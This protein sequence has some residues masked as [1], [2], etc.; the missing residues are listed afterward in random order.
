MA[1]P[2]E[3]QV[4]LVT[5]ATRGAGRGIA[6]EL[7]AAG[8]TVY[9]TGRTT[10]RQRSPLN[11]PETIE[12]TAERVTAAGGRG[13]AIQV[14]HMDISQVRDLV[15]RIE[16]EQDGQL[17]VLVNDIW[18]GQGEL[19]KN[20]HRPFWEHDLASR[21][22]IYHNAVDTH[23]ITSW[24]VAPIMVRRKTGL[25][26]GTTDGEPHWYHD[27]LFYDLSKKSVMRLAVA[28]AE[29]MSSYGI[30]GIAVSP[31]HLRSE[32]MLEDMGI[33]EETWQDWYWNN[34]VAE[35]RD[36]L[37]S[38]SPRY[39]G[40]VIAALAA[41]PEVSRWNGQTTAVRELAAHYDTMDV[42]G[43]TPGRGIYGGDYLHDNEPRREDYAPPPSHS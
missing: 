31:G 37:A 27:N 30:T 40:R 39:T 32:E 29:E 7:G 2:L 34:P 3:G 13:I 12:E 4:A 28:Y 1:K 42:N 20:W 6:I 24:H 25:I 15:Q 11:R 41:D 19:T 26:V 9:C 8:A 17:D 38:E 23:I 14:D 5:G 22:A 18:S 21:L 16:N 35:H 36:W 43:A 33:T 10:R